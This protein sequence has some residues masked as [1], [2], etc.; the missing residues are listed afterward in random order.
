MS[1]CFQALALAAVI[2]TTGFTKAD[3]PK[4]KKPEAAL[5]G[6][7]TLASLEVNG[8]KVSEEAIANAIMTVKDG[9][10]TFKMQDESEEGVF[11]VDA[12]KK[13]ATIDLDIKTGMSK[14][15]KQLG[16]YEVK[17]GAWKLCLNE[18][19]DGV[20]PTEIHANKDSKQLLF[21]FKKK[22]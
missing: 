19:G 8:Q 18:P 10:Y 9:K 21:I 5:D 7:W 20:R 14:D 2:L 22:P 3:D 16:I 4:D 11:K 6:T 1:R 15:M 13:P 12:S 17:D